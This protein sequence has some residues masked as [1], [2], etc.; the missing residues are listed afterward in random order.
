MKK[1]LIKMALLIG[2]L[3]AFTQPSQGLTIILVEQGFQDLAS[4]NP[5]VNL[6]GGASLMASVYTGLISGGLLVCN[7]LLGLG[8]ML[9]NSDE[10][11]KNTT[12]RIQSFGAEQEEAQRLAITLNNAGLTEMKSNQE[13]VLSVSDLKKD[14]P[15]FTKTEGFVKLLQTLQATTSN[16]Q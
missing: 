1:N 6:V 12:E 7:P 11:I 8:F 2:T 10:A 16:V 13:V 9:D 3:T 5:L 15:N 4:P 14:A